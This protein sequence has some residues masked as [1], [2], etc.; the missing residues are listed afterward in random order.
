MGLAFFLAGLVLIA[1]PGICAR[2]GRSLRPDEWARTSVVS[3]AVGWAI[4]EMTALLYAVPSLLTV[5]AGPHLDAFCHRMINQFAPGGPLA[6][7]A[8][9]VVAVALPALAIRTFTQMQRARRAVVTE[10]ARGRRSV[11]AG[12]DLFTLPVAEPIACSV[13]VTTPQIVISTGITDCL[14]DEQLAAVLDHEAAHLAHHHQEFLVVSGI[15]DRALGWLPFVRNSTAEVRLA[16][17]RW[18]DE[19]ASGTLGSRRRALRDALATVAMTMVAP[20][21]TA[22]S[23]FDTLAERL[24]ALN[25]PSAR[26]TRRARLLAHIPTS[27]T[28]LAVAAGAV[29]WRHQILMMLALIGH[30]AD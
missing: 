17:E 10:A 12:Y 15:I 5:A 25:Q 11:H 18:A 3:L 30:C 13:R 24:T 2:T 23:S 16:L 28:L 7:I 9:G 26:S 4:L 22:L 1:L 8:A 14:D 19:D 6:A 29:L 27:I 21:V 20:G